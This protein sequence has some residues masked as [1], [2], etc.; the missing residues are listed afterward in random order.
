MKMRFDYTESKR[1]IA[2]EGEYSLRFKKKSI[3]P[4]KESGKDR[5]EIDYELFDPPPGVSMAEIEK[6]NLRTWVSLSPNALFTLKNLAYACNQKITC[7]GCSTD[8]EGIL[9]VCPECQ[10]PLFEVDLDFI[11]TNSPK[12]FLKIEKDRNGKD[13]NNVVRY[14]RPT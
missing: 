5:I 7:A 1:P 4:A 2:P 14:S 8:Y 12:A 9:E 10:S 11:D 3:G 6:V 13:Q